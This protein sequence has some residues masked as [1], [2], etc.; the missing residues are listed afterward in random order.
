MALEHPR[1]F[2]AGIYDTGDG[3]RKFG[4]TAQS[5]ADRIKAERE[6]FKRAHH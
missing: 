4:E 3:S 1:I 2:D 6:E 5:A